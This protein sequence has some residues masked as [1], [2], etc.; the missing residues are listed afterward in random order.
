ML[1]LG[2][3]TIHCLALSVENRVEDGLTAVTYIYAYLYL[4]P[5]SSNRFVSEQICQLKLQMEFAQ[6]RDVDRFPYFTEYLDLCPFV[7]V[8]LAEQSA[9]CF[10]AFHQLGDNDSCPECPT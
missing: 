4:R 2:A 5:G 3:P 6:V 10:M 1:F 7:N 9:F 8:S